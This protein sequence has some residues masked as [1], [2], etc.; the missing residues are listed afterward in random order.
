MIHV[1]M[2]LATPKHDCKL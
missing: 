1:I 2:N